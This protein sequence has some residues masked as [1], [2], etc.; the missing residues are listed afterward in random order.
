MDFDTRIANLYQNRALL[1]FTHGRQWF[2]DQAN[3]L[4]G[5]SESTCQPGMD[6]ETHAYLNSHDF[7]RHCWESENGYDRTEDR[8][9][10]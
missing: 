4:F 6:P 3:P 8:F 7:F 9:P 2:I 5:W 1:I 10:E